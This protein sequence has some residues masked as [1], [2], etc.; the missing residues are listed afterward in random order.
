MGCRKTPS[1][2]S[3]ITWIVVRCDSSLILG[4]TAY[5]AFLTKWYYRMWRKVLSNRN[6]VQTLSWN[7][8]TES[9]NC[10]KHAKYYIYTPKGQRWLHCKQTHGHVA[11]WLKSFK[12]LKCIH[13][14]FSAH[15]KTSHLSMWG[16]GS[17]IYLN[18]GLKILLSAFTRRESGLA[19]RDYRQTRQVAV[20]CNNHTWCEVFQNQGI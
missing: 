11:S 18:L 8:A 7:L 16:V 1:A 10:N 17:L 19:V 9:A 14:A 12:G 4:H 2:C 6:S 3:F 20:K 13:R 15:S 5:I